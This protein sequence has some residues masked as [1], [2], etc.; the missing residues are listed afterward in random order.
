LLAA[1]RF[2]RAIALEDSG[3]VD[4]ALAQYRALLEEQP[5]HADAWHNHGLLL[6]RLGRLPEAE[7]SHRRYVSFFPGQARAH[8][9]LADVLL[10]FAR[11]EE[12]LEHASCAA[13][14]PAAGHLPSFTAGLACAMLERF[15]EAEVWFARAAQADPAR[16]QAFIA[17]HA[18]NGALDRDLDPRAIWLIRKFDPLQACDW[19]ERERYVER[20]ASL[21]AEPRSLCAPPLVF[22]S[23]TL[24]LPLD[25]RRRLADAVAAAVVARATPLRAPLRSARSSRP[26]RIGYVSPDFRTH[27]TG[28]LSTPIFRLHDKQRF[29]VHAFSLSPD[30][31]SRWRK[32]IESSA[33]HFHSLVG[34][35]MPQ[36]L[37]RIREQE[38][39]LLVDLAGLTTGAAPELFGARAAPV[40][41]SYL[42]FPGTSGTGIADY[43]IC[44]QVVV[45]EG[46][47]A[48][49]GEALAYL[50]ETFW[51][52]SADTAP[53]PVATRRGAGLP[54]DAIVL[55]AHHPG[56]KI[57]PAVFSAWM[58]ILVAVPA[59]V[60]WLLDD[61]PGMRANLSR[62]AQA[63][64]IPADRL[65]FAP[66]VPYAD[67][68]ARIP[69]ADLALD[70]PVYN[71][72]ATTLD[73]I[74]SG[75][76][77]LTCSAPGF[78]GRMAASALHAAG[79]GELVLKDLR[80]YAEAAIR[81]ATQPAE[82]RRLVQRVAEARISP[83]FDVQARTRQLESAYEQ[84]IERA[85]K[86]EAPRS[87]HVSSA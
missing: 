78:A 68:R 60:L 76:P 39:D 19:R 80:S 79:L 24:P 41:V 27:P 86:G 83:L 10:A 28:I 48:A 72:G 4:E 40:Q 12:A 3:R 7:Q 64:G 11:Y 55:Y 6:A 50:P 49:Y 58:E 33:G 75:V 45:P 66:R 84:M 59:A 57:E 62:E 42:G 29:E 17:R 13:A 9:D 70:T 22:R 2:A 14:L 30:D 15:A 69:L 85:A 52:C 67:Y 65:V 25:V 1:E 81:L 35:S 16:F 74:L 53:A 82:R 46:E 36:V 34:L 43:L 54:D 73:A 18:A 32:E 21:A 63:R 31:E 23:L 47:T 26:A 61:R 51:V 44:D 71:G 8:G 38:I 87:F 5:Q 20:F 77:V 56:Q 37:A